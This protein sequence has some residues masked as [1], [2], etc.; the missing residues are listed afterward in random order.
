ML[1]SDSV[2]VAREENREAVRNTRNIKDS[3]YQRI[4]CH[5]FKNDSKE[6]MQVAVDHHRK[7][8]GDSAKNRLNS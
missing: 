8:F 2:A 5:V 1:F 6:D 3:I 4:A 7:S